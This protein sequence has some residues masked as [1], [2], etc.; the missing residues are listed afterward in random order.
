M[1]RTRHVGRGS[2]TPVDAVFGGLGFVAGLGAAI[3]GYTLFP[4]LALAIFVFAAVSYLVGRAVPDVITDERKVQ[5]A[6]YFALL[7]AVGAAVVYAGY[8]LW[9]GMWLAVILGFVAGGI[10]QALLGRALFPKVR[11]EEAKELDRAGIRPEGWG[12]PGPEDLGYRWW[13]R[14]HAHGPQGS[15][16]WQR[17]HGDEAVRGEKQSTR[18]VR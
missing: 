5:R 14:V 10:A 13:R 15:Q 9:E 2:V 12:E 17:F 18:R 6:A 8:L 16:S 11:K 7:P 1:I 3:Y 4:S